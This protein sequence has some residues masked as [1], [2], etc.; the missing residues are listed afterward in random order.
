[1][2]GSPLHAS[3]LVSALALFAP[4]A[5]IADGFVTIDVM[6]RPLDN[7]VIEPGS[8]VEYRGGLV[9][10]SRERGF[11]SW[12]GIDF[13]S[14]GRL[15][16]I[17][18]DGKWMSLRLVEKDG[19]L[20]GIADPRMAPLL[21]DA[22]KP[23][24]RKDRGDAEGLRIV[25]RNGADVA[26]VSFEQVPDVRA[27]AAPDLSTAMPQH[28][29]VPRELDA[30]Y[31]NLGLEAIAV[32]PARSPVAGAT[33]VVAEQFLDKDGNHRGFILDGPRP[34][35]FTVRRTG[36]FDVSD[37]VFLA[38]GDLLILERKFGLLSGFTI[39]VRCIPGATLAPGALLDGWTMLEAD[40][41]NG[42]DNM[43]GMAVRSLPDGTTLL[44]LIS[45]DNHS[46]LQRTIVL[47]FA[48]KPQPTVVPRLRPD[49]ASG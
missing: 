44:T 17:A 33:V 29:P 49:R 36:E 43:E 25:Q 1:M 32:A 8:L 26:L 45:D 11:G 13:A 2:I 27:F 30:A 48:L 3:L 46:F 15:Y 37:A 28:I 14:D 18:D 41:R 6:T 38:N 31:D 34:G 21:D 39:R 16:A 47:E 7:F 20:T 9:L 42:I 5:A 24:T 22:G 10:A 4:A 12:S 35:G 40:A 19:R 23:I